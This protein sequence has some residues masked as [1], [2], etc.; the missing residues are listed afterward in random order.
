MPAVTGTS[1]NQSGVFTPTQ[2]TLDGST[3][4][5]TLDLTKN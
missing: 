3:D 5:L 1:L 4:T 2:V